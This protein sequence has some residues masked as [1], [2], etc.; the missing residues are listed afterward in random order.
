MP[1][2][3]KSFLI[4][5][6]KISVTLGLAWIVCSNIAQTPGMESQHFSQL[7][8]N[9]KWNYA[10]IAFALL[11]LSMFMG[12]FQWKVLLARQDIHLS[13]KALVQSYFVG[14]FFNNFMPGNVGGDVKKILDIRHLSGGKTK[15]ALSATAFDRFLSF[16]LLNCLALGVWFL[17]FRHDA[18]A[19]FLVVPSLWIFIGLCTFF[20]GVL[21]RRFGRKL[22]ALLLGLRLPQKFIQLYTDTRDKFHVYREPAFFAR[23]F[24]LSGTIQLMRV[25]VHF[26]CGLAIGVSLNVSWYLYL[27]PMIALVSALPISIGG[28]G[29]RELVA[30]SLFARVGVGQMESVV[31]QFLAY[32]MGLIISL[33]GGIMYIAKQF[34]K[35]ETAE[36][37]NE[38]AL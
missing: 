12:A 31:M 32:S 7:I 33:S 2:S 4:L 13:Y 19:T 22:E 18:R 16:L 10:W 17:F 6:A 29:P 25:L 37:K 30:Q 9:L 8:Q 1:R 36:L 34:R 3:F 38:S 27:V 24:A 5:F 26:F 35:S 21:S 14:L 20:A 15:E 11:S 23:T 28:F